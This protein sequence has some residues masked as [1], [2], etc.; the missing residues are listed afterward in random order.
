MMN[1]KDYMTFFLK[2][3]KVS[4]YFIFFLFLF[5]QTQFCQNDLTE[6]YQSES[7]DSS[8]VMQKSPWGAVLRSALLPGLGQFYNE[9]YWKIPVILGTLYYLGDVW[10][11]NNDDYKSYQSQYLTS[12]ETSTVG[13]AS[14]KRKRD[15]YHDQR[16]EFAIF[17]GLAYFLNLVDAYVDAQLFDFDVSENRMYQSYQL[18]LRIKL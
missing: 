17:I 9:S 18:N 5:L 3:T 12:L 8:F 10:I 14:L 13:D 16:D 4:I 1:L 7:S 2:L 11:R 15:F 6:T